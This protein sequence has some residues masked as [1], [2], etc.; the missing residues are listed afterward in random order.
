MIG[1]GLGSHFFEYIF[2]HTLE[3]FIVG[4]IGLLIFVTFL[5]IQKRWSHWITIFFFIFLCA[6]SLIYSSNR[7]IHMRDPLLVGLVDET[8]TLSGIIVSD[9]EVFGDKQKFTF[10]M[11][12][13][14]DETGIKKVSDKVLVT[15]PQYPSVSYGDEI[16]IIASLGRP[17]PFATEYGRMF[18]YD[19]YL[20]SQGIGYTMMAGDTQVV[21]SHRASSIIESL[22]HIKHKLF[23]S[24][25]HS[26]HEPYNAI[27][28]AMVFGDKSGILDDLQTA[29]QKTGLIHIMVLS[30]YNITI[31]AVV[32]LAVTR[33]L[34]RKFG[35]IISASAIVAF[36]LMTGLTPTSLRA[37][38][39]GAIGLLALGTFRRSNQLRAL[40]LAGAIMA[41][42]NPLLILESVSFQLSFIAT[43]GLITLSP[44]FTFV[45]IPQ[46]LGMREIIASTIA[47]QVAVLPLL[48]GK[49]GMVSVLGLITNLFV[50]PVVPIIMVGTALSA[51]SG[52]IIMPIGNFFGII[53]EYMVRALVWLVQLCQ[54]VGV[55]SFAHIGQTWAF[56]IGCV[57][58]GIII[59]TFYWIQN[60]RLRLVY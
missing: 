13:I 44:L 25:S 47:T 41:I 21:G 53:I 28:R 36:L 14:Y 42:I 34:G 48:V 7:A 24:L 17:E 19:Q 49:I 6:L 23:D 30:G 50:V 5:A 37:G 43:L 12:H 11:E 26:M 2:Y 57:V 51:V 1:C 59:G 18:A 4:I 29:F 31:I 56:I 33:R 16:K 3:I 8:V 52:L 38:I 39:M 9:P 58:S 60:R 55:I 46:T 32:L 40:F 20:R 35:I 15:L 45:R 10:K 22:L 54:H 27:A